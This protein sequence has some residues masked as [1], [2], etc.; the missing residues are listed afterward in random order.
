MKR[1]SQFRQTAAVSAALLALLFL[2][3]LAVVVPFRDSLFSARD[4]VDEHEAEPFVPGEL[5]ASV[6]L[7]VLDGDTV[8]EMDLGTYLVAVVRAEMPASFEPEALKAQAVAARTYTLYK[9]RT[10]GNHGEEADICTDST[11][12]QAYIAEDRARENWGADADENEAKIE[13]AVHD[14]DGETILYDG[15]PILAVFHSSSAGQTRTAGEVWVSDLPYLQ[16]VSSPEQGDAIP[17]YYSRAE[18]TAEQF[19]EKVLSALPEADLSGP[20]DTWLQN[21]VTD[22]AGSVE[23]VEVGGV[24][25]KGS[26]VRSILGLRSA[27]FE[28]EIQEQT[29]VFYV[30]GFGHGVGMS[31][32]GANQMAAEGADY[33]EILTHYYTGVTVE[34]YVPGEG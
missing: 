30:T 29:L 34:P 16:A 23:T 3:P 8:E 9:I 6:T 18:F 19:R 2:L 32:Y 25:V 33:R 14:T 24:A 4:T 13:A 22:T 10:G 7:R 5:D 17:N 26:T 11:C 21:A 27:C 12:C 31:Q 20:M 1:T 15:V 28:W